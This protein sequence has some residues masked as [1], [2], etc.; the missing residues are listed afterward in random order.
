MES[1]PLA[2]NLPKV[3]VPVGWK[4]AKTLS[5]NESGKRKRRIPGLGDLVGGYLNPGTSSMSIPFRL[6]TT[7]DSDHYY[8]E[9]PTRNSYE[10][11]C[12]VLTRMQ[13]VAFM[14]NS[15][16]VGAKRRKYDWFS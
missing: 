4:L 14:V 10:R 15:D 12:D 9:F 16:V 11:L 3:C 2:S 1:F 6:L 13:G 7:K 8:A 5:A